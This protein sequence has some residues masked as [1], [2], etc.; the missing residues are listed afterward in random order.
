MAAA[1]SDYR[2]ILKHYYG[3][4]KF[5]DE[6]APVTINDATTYGVTIQPATGLTTGQ[7][8]Y[9]I[10][11]IHHLTSEENNGNHH[12]YMDVLDAT[13]QRLNGTKISVVWPTGSSSAVIDKPAN[14]PGTN[15]PLTGGQVVTVSVLGL[16]SDSA[17]GISTAHPDEPPV[18]AWGHNGNSVGHHSFL[19]VWQ[20]TAYGGTVT[21]PV[22][23]PTG[24][25]FTTE[26]WQQLNTAQQALIVAQ[27]NIDAIMTRHLH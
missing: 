18:T 14:E 24:D 4:I 15:A 12:V 1:G 10:I 16:P 9:R 2:T 17:V 26:D 3:D 13:G 8:Y 20:V 21:P 6:E 11:Q 7:L 5:S 22:D 27:Q 25:E 23:P 19:V